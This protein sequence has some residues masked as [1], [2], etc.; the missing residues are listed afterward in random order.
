MTGYC[1]NS[2]NYQIEGE[3]NSLTNSELIPTKLDQ[4]EIVALKLV[5][6]QISDEEIR[7]KITEILIK[8]LAFEKAKKAKNWR[9][10][11]TCE[12]LVPAPE[13]YCTVCRINK[14]RFN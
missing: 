4:S 13:K 12:T 3:T 1:K 2:Q 6:E 7:D 5:T 14:N 11:L 9:I 8:N 10:C